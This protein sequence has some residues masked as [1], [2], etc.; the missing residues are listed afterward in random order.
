MFPQTHSPLSTHAGSKACKVLGFCVQNINLAQCLFQNNV[1][2]LVSL[3]WNMNC[4]V[5]TVQCYI[6]LEYQFHTLLF[7]YSKRPCVR[8][9]LPFMSV[10]SKWWYVNAKLW[11]LLYRNGDGV[12]STVCALSFRKWELKMVI[13][14][15]LH[16][17]EGIAS[18]HP[19][20]I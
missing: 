6:W 16:E 15:L 17:E 4:N 5:L 7:C 11:P 12:S 18:T 9:A 2:Q 1:L 19:I 20:T 14:H 10:I 13:P 8:I 3:I